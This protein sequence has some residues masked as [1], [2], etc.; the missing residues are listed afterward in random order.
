MEIEI[1]IYKYLGR[2]VWTCYE[3]LYAFLSNQRQ[4]DPSKYFQIDL[5]SLI[6]FR[7]F[8]GKYDFNIAFIFI[9]F[10]TLIVPSFKNSGMYNIFISFSLLF[11]ISLKNSFAC[12]YLNN[13]FKYYEISREICQNVKKCSLIF[14]CYFCKYS[15]VMKWI[16]QANWGK[17]K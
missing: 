2:Q 10:L 17:K 8:K 13:G 7:S 5:A 12:I 3:F 4:Y 11:F 1:A 16:L 6:L 9:T 14:Q 15:I